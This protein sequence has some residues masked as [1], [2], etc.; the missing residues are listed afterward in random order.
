MLTMQSAI[1]FSYP[2]SDA[3]SY[4]DSIIELPEIQLAIAVMACLT[5]ISSEPFAPYP[6]EDSPF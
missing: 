2:A 6:D 5:A 3:E 4:H 1:L